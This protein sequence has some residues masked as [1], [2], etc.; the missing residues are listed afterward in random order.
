MKIFKPILV[1]ALI[2]IA[3]Y[4][5]FSLIS[6]NIAQKQDVQNFCSQKCSYNPSSLF[7]EFSGDNG[8]K[9]FTTKNECFGYCSQARQGFVY[10]FISESYASLVASPPVSD[11]LKSIHLK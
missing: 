6:E 1:I 10:R 11:W 8:T 9:G 5:A 7:W 3:G 4:L 2:L